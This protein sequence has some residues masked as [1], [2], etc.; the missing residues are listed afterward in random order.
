MLNDYFKDKYG[1]KILKLSINAGFSCPNRENGLNGCLFC[2]E[3]GSGEF[4]GNVK[5]SI[6]EQI[7]EQI[8]FL[9]YKNKSDS[10]IAYFQSFTNTYDSIDNLKRKYF[11]ALNHEKVIGLAIATRPDCINN[12]IINLLEEINEKYELW[13][14]LGFQ[15]SNENTAKLIRRGYIN[16]VFKNTV[17]KLN[18]SKIKTVAH[19]IFGLPYES[20]KDWLNSINYL[21]NK[22]LWG[23]KFHSLY[24]QK[25]SDLYD[26]YLKNKFKI[27]DKEEYISIVSKALGLIPKE[28]VV[29]RVTGDADKTELFLPKWSADKLSVIC[30][31]QKKL[32]ED[33]ILQGSNYIE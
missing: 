17:N 2:S 5:K 4:G 27:I 23:I 7:E 33:S 10:Y 25:N 3:A 21:A 13:V 14:E 11:E 24:I 8:K 28:Y 15:T 6:T 30:S 32:K 18:N 22:N 31:I 19:L 12:S 9:S 26:F 29:H 16:E 1:K 20:E